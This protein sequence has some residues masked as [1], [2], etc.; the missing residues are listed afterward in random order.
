MHLIIKLTVVAVL[1]LFAMPIAAAEKKAI[2]AVEDIVIFPWGLT[3]AARIDTGAATSSLDVCDF[4][5]VGKYVTFTLADRCG[6]HKIRRPLLGT[7]TIHT[8]D[9]SG[10]RPIVMMEICLGST[11]IK[12]RVT[13]NDRS[14]ME[15]PV[16]IGRRTLRGKYIVDVSSKN[17]L[18]PTCPGVKPDFI[19]DLK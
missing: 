11:L 10:Q 2:G 9:G 3:L 8:S 4:K 16:L 6:G 19:P 12:T 18:P 14:K 7:K 15:Y 13:L 1:C 17:L 5:V